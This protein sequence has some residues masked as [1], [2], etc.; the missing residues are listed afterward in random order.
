MNNIKHEFHSQN[1]KSHFT[2]MTNHIYNK[3]HK[4]NLY[5]I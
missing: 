2:L 1:D 3:E 5:I 4:P